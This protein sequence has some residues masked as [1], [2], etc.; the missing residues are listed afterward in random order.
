MK[1]QA[2]ICIYPLRIEALGEAIETFRK[3]FARHELTVTTASMS[4]F[5]SGEMSR[6]FDAC[7]DCFDVLADTYDVV[8][9]IKISNA[10]SQ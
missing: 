9:E 10:C 4:S 2:E 3:I 1:V 8:M 6:I 5:T 7:R